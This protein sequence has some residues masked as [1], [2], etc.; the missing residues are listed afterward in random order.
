MLYSNIQCGV[1]DLEINGV[2][3]T[4]YYTPI[5]QFD[6]TVALVVAKQESQ[7]P[8][9]LLGFVLLLITFI[10]IIIVYKSLSLWRKP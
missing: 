5:Q 8:L 10:G 4:V 2:S 1:I 6:W 3:S 9:F 7:K